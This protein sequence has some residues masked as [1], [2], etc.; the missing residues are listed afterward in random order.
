MIPSMTRVRAR[1]RLL[2]AILLILGATPLWTVV[3]RADPGDIGFEGP[4]SAGAGTAPTGQKPES[5]L[6][7]AGGIWWS[8]LYTPSG[9]H[10]ERL[11]RSPGTWGRTRGVRGRRAHHRA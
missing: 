5:K 1:H 8:I 9:H 11:R 4:S 7:Y 2:I 6:W 10:I 3:A